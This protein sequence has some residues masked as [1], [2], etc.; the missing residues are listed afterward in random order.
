MLNKPH[1]TEVKQAIPRRQVYYKSAARP[2][3]LS[4]CWQVPVASQVVKEKADKGVQGEAFPAPGISLSFDSLKLPRHPLALNNHHALTFEPRVQE[5]LS[6]GQ[7]SIRVQ[8]Q[9]EKETQSCCSPISR[10][11]LCS[12]LHPKP[13]SFVWLPARQTSN[14]MTYVGLPSS[15]IKKLRWVHS[16]FLFQHHCEGAVY[17]H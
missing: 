6:S 16:V 10:V 1:I 5:Q 15:A 9:S 4:S 17:V 7:L 13:S 14:P 8:A 12:M 3:E 2:K 11:I